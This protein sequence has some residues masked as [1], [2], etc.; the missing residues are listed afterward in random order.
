MYCP[1]CDAPNADSATRCSS[2]GAALTPKAETAEYHPTENVNV[3]QLPMKW[4]YFL[5]YVD[6]FLSALLHLV[7]AVLTALLPWHYGVHT[8][9]AILCTVIAA[10]SSLALCAYVL[11][12]RSFLARYRK[13]GPMLYYIYLAADALIPLLTLLLNAL[14]CPIL[15]QDA[16]LSVPVINLIVLALNYTYFDKRRAYFIY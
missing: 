14:L 13:R 7:S 6:L 5:I 3:P 4:Y 12:V 10:V 2:C 9:G 16:T 1:H 15:N 8:P 11:V